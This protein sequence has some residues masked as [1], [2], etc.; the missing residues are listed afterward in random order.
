[1]GDINIIALELGLSFHCKAILS[2]VNRAANNSQPAGKWRASTLR[3][4]PG[5]GHLPVLHTQG[6]H[7]NDTVLM[8]T[9]DVVQLLVEPLDFVLVGR[10]LF[11]NILKLI[12]R[13]L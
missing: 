9:Q 3:P 7:I 11:F 12:H 2:N 5:P 1:M 8:A 10:P 4:Q 6:V 13:S